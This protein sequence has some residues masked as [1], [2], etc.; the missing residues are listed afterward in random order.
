MGCN[1]GKVADQKTLENLNEPLC[2]FT[3]EIP[4][5][6]SMGNYDDNKILLGTK[7]ELKIFDY[8]TKSLNTL[9]KEHVSR[10]NCVIKLSN[11]EIAT[12]GQDKTIKIWKI[13]SPKSLITLS[14]HKS[15]IWSLREIKGNK[16]ITGS[17]DRTAIIWDLNKQKK[18]FELFHGE[19]KE[20]SDISVVLQ[21]KSGYVLLCYQ[22][23]LKLFDLE[24]KEKLTEIIIPE[25]VWS[26]LELKNGS[27]AAGLGNGDIAILEIGSEIK[28]K[29]VLKGHPKTVNSIIEL[30]NNKIVSAS[31]G[32]KKNLIMWDLKSNFNYILE[33]HN[34]SVIS[35]VNITRDKFASSSVKDKL[36]KIWE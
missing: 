14:G 11:N 12:A 35:L 3:L 27:V 23:E 30:S 17:S 28:I 15:M 8:M 2:R 6:Y 16:L 29:N 4:N 33:G 32:E 36:F 19:I 7:D 1:G 13:N 24:K 9:S 21:L 5:I 18:D 34:G 22:D 25:G 31:D 20:K 10:I 26:I